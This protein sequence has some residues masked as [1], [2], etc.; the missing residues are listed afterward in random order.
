MKSPA[1]A[2]FLSL[3]PGLGHLYIGRFIRA[4]FYLGGSIGVA[5]FSLFIGIAFTGN[6][7]ILLL[8]SVFLCLIWFVNLLDMIVTISNKHNGVFQ[9]KPIYQNI[10]GH[11]VLVEQPSMLDPL[12]QAQ[13]DEQT[14]IL[15][16]A[17]I[18][19][20]AHLYM[21]AT[22]RGLSIMLTVIIALVGPF[23]IHNM[24]YIPIILLV[25]FFVPVILIYSIFDARRIIKD[26]QNDREVVDKS[27]FDVLTNKIAQD[28]TG[29]MALLFSFIPGFG[30]LVL[31]YAKQGIQLLLIT[32]MSLLFINEFHMPFLRY[33]LILIWAYSFFDTLYILRNQQTKQ[34]SNDTLLFAFQSYK[35][36]IGLGL[37]VVGLYFALD[38]FAI[39]M[40]EN[41]STVWHKYYMRHKYNVLSAIAAFII[42][43]VGIK[44]MTSSIADNQ[45]RKEH[46]R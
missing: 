4:F 6:E 31:G 38:L 32:V 39:H 33:F 8:G 40:L 11:M 34:Q 3:I 25:V 36:W 19:G 10:N 15:F 12:E 35:R 13:R 26:K 42:I 5:L 43:F 37:I 7:G 44:L 29:D 20:L 17:L 2:F 1:V 18:P 21:N 45:K 23:I 22:K 30:H 16:L 24:L 46:K 27:I 28:K 41:I 14:K 9:P